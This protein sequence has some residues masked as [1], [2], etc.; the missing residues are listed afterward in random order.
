MLAWSEWAL[1]RE[2]RLLGLPKRPCGHVGSHDGS[3][4]N[5][6]SFGGKSTNTKNKSEQWLSIE[7]RIMFER[8]AG[9]WLHL[10]AGVEYSTSI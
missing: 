8:W 10:G 1:G 9:S 4:E 2:D 7:C 6:K 5:W 3:S